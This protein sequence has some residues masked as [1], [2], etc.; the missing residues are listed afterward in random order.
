M[1]LVP[2]LAVCAA[3]VCSAETAQ[4]PINAAD[5]LKIKRITGL[6]ISPAATFAVYT[7]QSIHTGKDDK[8]D[9]TYAYRSHIWRVDLGKPGARPRQLTF[10]DRRDSDIA[11]SPDGNWVAFLREEGAKPDGPKPQVWLLPLQNP[12]EAHAVT[13]L[14][15]GARDPVWHPEGTRLL[16]AVPVPASKLEGKPHYALERPLRDWFDGGKLEGKPDGD[17]AAIR[18]WLERNA[19]RDNPTIA[20]R[21]AFQD[22]QALAREPRIAHLFAIDLAG[23][24]RATQLTHG[25]YSHEGHAY[26]PDGKRIAYIST[27][28]SADHPDRLR[29]KSVWLMD[30]G[31]TNPR[32]LLDD[33]G[34]NASGVAW[35]P[36]SDSVLV[37][38]QRHDEPTFRQAR[39]LRL[40]TGQGQATAVAESWESSVA[41][42]LVA[43]DGSILFTSNWHGGAPLLRAGRSG[44]SELVSGP[45]GVTDFDE[46]EGRIVY[47]QVS[48]AN[49]H[50]LFVREKDGGTRQLSFHNSEWLAGKLL[51]LPTEKWIKRPNGQLVQSWVMNPVHA[52]AGQ[53]YPFVLDMHGGPHT[54]WGPGEFSM[55]HEFQLLCAWGYGVVYSNPRGSSGYG[56]AFQRGNFQDWGEGPASDVLAALDDAVET[57]PFVD[58]DRLFL[59][60]GSYAGYLTA[61]IVAHDHRFKAAAAQRGVYDLT[62]FY[63]EGNAFSLVQNSFGGRPYEPAVRRLLDAQSPFTHVAKVRTPLLILHGAQDRRT[64]VS[65]SEMM[66]RALKDLGRSVEYVS[67]PGIGHELTRSGPPL[68]RMDH[69]LRIVEFFERYSSNAS[70]AP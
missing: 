51:S 36:E 35:Y 2:A 43:S 45:I 1:R 21:L 13:T 55:W 16:V 61:W 26:S 22:E 66:Y 31:G 70:P 24:N 54:M 69:M 38:T 17:R 29:R 65:Q 9:A 46:A 19:S 56:Y 41:D 18:S 23:G 8:G 49:P 27:P 25:F 33:A 39:L 57:N 5:L 68:Q 52:R 34:E 4:K 53:K 37:T 10:G 60:G 50:E 44:V 3:M 62:T 28:K 67:Y 40:E 7:L 11:L 14:E 58:K 12:G 59:T 63:G 48:V 32:P 15:E 6:A 42:S 20:T 30:A 47:A 64:G